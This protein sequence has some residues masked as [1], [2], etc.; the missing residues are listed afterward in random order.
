MRALTYTGRATLRILGPDD[1]LDTEREFRRGEALE[2]SE[3]DADRIL[4]DPDR[5]PDFTE[6]KASRPAGT[7]GKPA[8][9]AD[10]GD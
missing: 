4:A 8:D 1:G 9:N 5:F 3:A 7:A 2:V 10:Q 6:A